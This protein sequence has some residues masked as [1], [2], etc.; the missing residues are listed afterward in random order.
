MAII[1]VGK[2]GKSLGRAIAYAAKDAQFTDDKN[3]LSSVNCPSAP[4]EAI[5]AMQTTKLLFGKTDGRQYK[6]YIQSFAKNETN[7]SLANEI[8]R[9]WAQE[10]FGNYGF[11]CFIGTHIHSN[12]GCIHNHI[13]INSVNFETGYKIQLAKHDLKRLKKTSD[14]LCR[15]YGLSV[16]EKTK[17]KRPDRIQAYS[18]EKFAILQKNRKQSYLTNA[19]VALE[20]TLRARP[21]TRKAFIEKMKENGWNTVF[22][23]TKHI[24]FIN[25]HN[26]SQRVRAANLAKTFQKPEWSRQSIEL[27]FQIDRKPILANDKKEQTQFLKEL[28]YSLQSMRRIK[29]RLYALHSA[30]SRLPKTALRF[31]RRGNKILSTAVKFSPLEVLSAIHTFEKNALSIQAKRKARNFS[32]AFPRTS[33]TQV[34]KKFQCLNTN[35]GNQTKNLAPLLQATKELAAFLNDS[36]I[37]FNPIVEINDEE[38]IDFASLSQLDKKVYLQ[39]RICH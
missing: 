14:Q 11:E 22:R 15:K 33:W 4:N 26:S 23:G 39:Q 20:Q 12:S 27:S 10:N 17:I 25:L 9:E 28:R 13:I 7:A 16:I 37:V 24:T 38:H 1:K 30:H 36:N 35:G 29:S 32:A 8:G 31:Q 19:A 34:F 18:N 3:L 2:S 21:K 5:E 6:S